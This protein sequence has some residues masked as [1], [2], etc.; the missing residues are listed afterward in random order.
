MPP[1]AKKGGQDSPG[2]SYQ[3]KIT[4]REI[5]PPIWR[6]VMVRADTTLGKLHSVIQRSMGWE[7]C[8]LHQFEANGER[9][10]PREVDELG[11]D[12]DENKARLSSVLVRPGDR[13][14]YEYD[15]G[16]SWEHDV[17]LEKTLPIEK[18]V[19]Y[20]QVIAGKR[21][22]PP[23]DC[24][25]VPGYY[26]FLEALQDPEHPEHEEMKEWC[27]GDFDAE[28]FSVQKANVAFHGGWVL[29]EPAG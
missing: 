14:L 3:L 1:S 21:A 13:M 19:R 15:F 27:G 23:E 25:G 17:V 26:E 20:P 11:E 28:A 7:N 12:R 22:C 2:L 18:G 8:H 16:D 5:K 10:S 4:L 24:G 6:R 29:S 9:Y